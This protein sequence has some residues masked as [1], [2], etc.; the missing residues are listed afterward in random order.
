MK[1][2]ERVGNAVGQRLAEGGAVLDSERGEFYRLNGSAFDVW[3]VLDRPLTLLEILDAL[4]QEYG[5]LDT[6]SQSEVEDLLK[7]LLDLG[8]LK[9]D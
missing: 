4:E 2:F 1:R 9:T 6:T 7:Y 3:E 8:L 5:V